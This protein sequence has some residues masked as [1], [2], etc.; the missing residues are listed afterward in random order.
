MRQARLV[1]GEAV[2]GW[3]GEV[4]PLVLRAFDVT[5]PVAAVVLD[6]DALLAAGPDRRRPPTRTC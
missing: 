3:A 1:A 5:P 6:L 2:V 4:H